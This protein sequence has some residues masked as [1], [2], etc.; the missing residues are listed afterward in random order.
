MTERDPRGNQSPRRADPTMDDTVVIVEANPRGRLY[1]L[2]DRLPEAE[3]QAA[4]RY[5]QYLAEYGDPLFRTAMAAPEEDEELS[6]RGRR[7]LDEGRED[8]AAGRTYTLDEVKR[9]LDL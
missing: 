8:L 7:L 9:E 1:R 6:A 5:L 4:E 2:V 3:I